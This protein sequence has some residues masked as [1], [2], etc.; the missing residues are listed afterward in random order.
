MNTAQEHIPFRDITLKSLMSPNIQKIH[1]DKIDPSM[2]L[3]FYFK[4]IAEFELFSETIDEFNSEN[5][6]DMTFPLYITESSLQYENL[7]NDN[8]Q[9]SQDDSENEWDII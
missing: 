5:T 3:C 2:S 8:K 6:P 7:E 9:Y 4:N 1:I